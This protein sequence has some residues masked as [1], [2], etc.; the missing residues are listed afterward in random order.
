MNEIK[1]P[2]AATT[3]GG[4][5]GD[6][7]RQQKNG[8]TGENIAHTGEKSK[9][10]YTEAAQPGCRCKH[11]DCEYRSP[12]Q[13]EEMARCNY[14]IVTGHSRLLWHRKR[15]LPTEPSECQLYD[16]GE[17]E[18]LTKEKAVIILPSRNDTFTTGYVKNRQRK[19]KEPPPSVLLDKELV[20][21]FGKHY[22]SGMPDS[23]I[24]IAT[25]VDVRTVHKWRKATGLPEQWERN[26][27][28]AKE[29]WRE[30]YDCGIKIKVIAAVLHVK[31]ETISEWRE[32]AGL[33]KRDLRFRATKEML[34]KQKEV[35]KKYGI[36]FEKE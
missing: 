13:N 8:A 19:D 36:Q 22:E 24:S 25:G 14:M 20:T 4:F 6:S 26:R 34:E 15:G 33:P 12:C 7:V 5:A 35:K 30:L 29:K 11:P 10:I 9:S 17:R 32:A 23:Q 31:L 3:A 2:S 16:P 27:E 21:A 28:E 1:K 18:L